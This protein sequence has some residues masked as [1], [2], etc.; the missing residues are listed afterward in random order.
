MINN[1]K[2]AL[3]LGVHSF[4]DSYTKVGIQ[5]IA[6]GLAQAGWQVDY[7]SI[8]SSP[9]DLYGSQRRKRFQRIWIRHQDEKGIVIKSGLIEYAF[10]APFP[11]NRHF[12]RYPWQLSLYDSLLPEWVA[13]KYYNVC[14]HDVTANAI[15]LKRVQSKYKI[16]RLNDLPEGF[17][18]SLSQQVINIY[19]KR[20]NSCLYNEIWVAHDPLRKYALE[21]N[22]DN[23]VFTIRNGVDDNSMEICSGGIKNEKTAV[24]IG[25]IEQWFDLE[26]L[27]KTASLLRDW[28][29]DVIGPLNRSWRVKSKNIRRLKPISRQKL[30]SVLSGYQVGL[31]PFRDISGRLSFV[32]RPL[33][34]FEYIASGLGV[35]CTDVGSLKSGL[36]ELASYGNSPQAFADAIQ[37]EAN[38]AK[39]RSRTECLQIVRPHYWWHVMESINQRL[40]DIRV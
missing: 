25:S 39:T 21:M 18:N 11:A 17:K 35:A 7:I 31:I 27:D 9:F 15:Y 14:I 37:K 26:L 32:E 3:I 16:L 34:F 23:R 6:E 38:R 5:F 24:F 2:N 10:R 40:E 28:Q 4:I 20:L 1:E 30:K 29:F 36:G 19:E 22:P 33:K 13:K 8:F 12:L